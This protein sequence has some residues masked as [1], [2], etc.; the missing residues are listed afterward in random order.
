MYTGSPHIT[1]F[2]ARQ[3]VHAELQYDIYG[4][5]PVYINVEYDA[6]SHNNM[7]LTA[8]PSFIPATGTTYQAAYRAMQGRWG[9]I[10]RKASAGDIVEVVLQGKVKFPNSMSASNVGDF[11]IGLLPS[12]G[13]NSVGASSPDNHPQHFC[14]ANTNEFGHADERHTNLN[15]L[16]T[17][18]AVGDDGEYI[19]WQG[20]QTPQISDYSHGESHRVQAKLMGSLDGGDNASTPAG[21][22]VRLF[23]NT[24]GDLMA[25]SGY[26]LSPINKSS[27]DFIAHTNNDGY[28]TNF[29]HWGICETGGNAGD[30]VDIVV[31]GHVQTNQTDVGENALITHIQEDGDLF[32]LGKDIIVSV[33]DQQ[34]TNDSGEWVGYNIADANVNVDDAISNKMKITTTTDNED[35][36]AL[37][38]TSAMETLVVGKKYIISALIDHLGTGNITM[39]YELGGATSGDITATTSNRYYRAEITCTDASGPLRIYNVAET[40]AREIQIDNVYVYEKYG[41]TVDENAPSTNGDWTPRIYGTTVNTTGKICI[42][43]GINRASI[44]DFKEQQIVTAELYGGT[45]HVNVTAKLHAVA[46][47]VNKFGK[48]V[49]KRDEM[50]SHTSDLYG[51][52]QVPSNMWGLALESGTPGD[53]IKVLVS[54]RVS[55]V[56]TS[57]DATWEVG[58]LLMQIDLDGKKERLTSQKYSLMNN[59]DDKTITGSPN[60]AEF[61]PNTTLDNFNVNTSSGRVEITGSGNGHFKPSGSNGKEGAILAK[62]NLREM[63]RDNTTFNV[64]NYPPYRRTFLMKADVWSSGGTAPNICFAINETTTGSSRT[65]I[66]RDADGSHVVTTTQKTFY[67][68]IHSY[69][70][71]VSGYDDYMTIS[72]TNNTTDAWYFTNV[73]L[74]N[75]PYATAGH[76]GVCLNSDKKEWYIH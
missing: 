45:S 34:F 61:S 64:G 57:S 43:P 29:G 15:T 14:H 12:E 8:T 47:S 39:R 56:N 21:V 58:D 68:F 2:S 5:C 19:I 41:N 24:D 11:I 17:I 35:E 1:N 20:V 10:E 51:Q 67:A 65:Y 55:D 76:L 32:C 75:I 6:T 52:Y 46:L 48:L 18:I 38:P 27:V 69:T 31:A 16:G 74:L 7:K 40:T 44:R 54:G 53:T 70:D 60:W 23:I 25:R 26:D 49:A 9:V 71:T 28:W 3:A 42:F 73:E 66:P 50:S 62:A 13:V 30:V 63:H 36:G 72:Q 59:S 33:N 4:A 22:P 37:L